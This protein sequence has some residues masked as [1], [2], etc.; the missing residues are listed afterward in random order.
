ML[1]ACGGGSNL[2]NNAPA[3]EIAPNNQSAAVSAVSIS[4]APL[5]YTFSVTVQSP[6]T[7]CDQYA[8]WWE[9]LRADGSLVYRR[10]LGHSHVTEQPF[11]RSGGPIELSDNE[12]II[13]RAHM[14]N[15]GY[16]DQVFRGSVLEGLTKSTLGSAFMDELAFVDPL[17]ASCAF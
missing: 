16:G 10:I 5:S 15:A 13:V 6:D 14:N 12:Q 7:G 1:S 4:G 11:T 9:V 2:S 3:N 17:P 8:D